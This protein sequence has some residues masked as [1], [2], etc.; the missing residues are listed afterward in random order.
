MKPACA[1]SVKSVPHHTGIWLRVPQKGICLKSQQEQIH[2][3]LIFIC[4]DRTKGRQKRRVTSFPPKMPDFLGNPQG[5]FF[6][7]FVFREKKIWIGLNDIGPGNEDNFRWED[8]TPLGTYHPWH[9]GSAN[10]AGTCNLV[11]HALNCPSPLR[12][13]FVLHDPEN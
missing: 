2:C 10:N 8:S 12:S 11:I 7:N 3:L 9:S 4:F 6:Q 5:S 13:F 1:C